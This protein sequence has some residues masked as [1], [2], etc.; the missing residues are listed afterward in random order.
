M[1]LETRF[2]L[3]SMLERTWDVSFRNASFE[4]WIMMENLWLW[5]VQWHNDLVGDH[6]LEAVRIVNI[7]FFG[8]AVANPLEYV[9]DETVEDNLFQKNDIDIFPGEK[10]E[11]WA[12]FF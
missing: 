1:Y 2:G 11:N 7:Y 12:I 5:G 10:L 6:R 4:Y 3:K 8:Q 9:E